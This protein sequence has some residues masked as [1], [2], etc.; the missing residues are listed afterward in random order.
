MN[1]SKKQPATIDE[2]IATFPKTIQDLL[3]KLREVIKDAAPSAEEAIRYR[4]PTFR[5]KHNLVHFAAF[6]KHIGFYPTSS[7]VEAFKEELSP[8][9]TSKGAIQFPLDKPLPFDLVRK[10]VQ[11]RV[12]EEL[13]KN[14]KK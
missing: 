6:K 10:I 3:E 13:D 7:G 5:L 11:F 9:K 2:Y 14:K 4:M 1:T 8:Y 12:K